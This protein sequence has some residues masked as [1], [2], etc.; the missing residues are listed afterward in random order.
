MEFYQ[1]TSVSDFPTY[2][3]LKCQDDAV[4]WSGF[5]SKPDEQVLYNHFVNKILK[6]D[7]T[8]IY[9]LKDNNSVVGYVQAT[10]I[11]ADEVEFSAT[12]I[13][14]KFQ[15]QGYLQDMTELFLDEMKKKGFVRVIGWASEKNKP[16]I[17]NLKINQFHK[18]EEFESRSM[19]LLGGEHRFFKW[20]KEL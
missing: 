17:F 9:Y 14:S 3:Q 7:N 18:T 10:I 15:G 11:N 19:P 6:S 12:N 2:Y 4:L 8:I 1:V 5:N 20:I 16:A 13:F